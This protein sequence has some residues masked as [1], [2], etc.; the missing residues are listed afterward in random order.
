M[1]AIANGGRSI[2]NGGRSIASGG[3]SIAS[4]GGYIA[5]RDTNW[6]HVSRFQILDVQL[7]LHAY[8]MFQLVNIELL[9][10]VLPCPDG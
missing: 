3:R 5:N 10:M 4:G 7:L 6:P 2:A 9:L 1:M 8:E